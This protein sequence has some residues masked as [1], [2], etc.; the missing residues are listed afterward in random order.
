MSIDTT[1]YWWCVY[2]ATKICLL[3]QDFV[4][5]LLIRS[6]FYCNG[7]LSID[8]TILLLKESLVCC[9]EICL[10]PRKLYICSTI[11]LLALFVIKLLIRCVVGWQLTRQ[12]LYWHENLMTDTKRCLLIDTKVC[13]LAR[14]YGYWHGNLSIDTIVSWL[15][16]NDVYWHDSLNIGTIL[17][18]LA[19]QFVYWYDILAID[20]WR[21]C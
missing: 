17:W 15:I 8:T 7:D 18:L 1:I 5:R 11:S 10:L 4:Y 13:L 21:W 16:Q 6:V 9:H 20:N 14:Y 2:V 12:F 3:K 19:R